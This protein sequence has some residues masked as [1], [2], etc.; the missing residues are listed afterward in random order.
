MFGA[1]PKTSKRQLRSDPAHNPPAVLYLFIKFCCVLLS[2]CG[3]FSLLLHLGVVIF[4]FLS[5]F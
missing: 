1:G 2:F 4:F 5:T 3:M